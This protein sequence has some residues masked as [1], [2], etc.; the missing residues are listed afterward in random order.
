MKRFVL[1]LFV[2]VSCPLVS[3]GQSNAIDTLFSINGIPYSSQEFVEIYQENSLNSKKQIS[4]T[5]ALDL[6]ILFQLKINEAK[7]I[8]IDTL[9]E[10]KH[11]IQIG[12]DIAFNAFLYPRTIS[13][14]QIQEAHERLQYF[15]RAQQ[16]LVKVSKRANAKDTLVA[17]YKAQEIYKNLLK[18]KSFAKIARKYSHDPLVKKND[19]QLGYFTAFD[20]DYDFETAAYT[21]SVGAF[22]KPVH[23]TF[24]YHIIQILEK[25]ANPGKIKFRHILLDYPKNQEQKTKVKIDSLYSILM[26]GADFAE[27]AKKYST[28]DQTL[29]TKEE[30]PWFGLYETNPKIEEIAFKLKEIGEISKPIKTK[31]AYLI[32]QLVDRKDYSSLD[33]C[34][35]EIIELIAKDDR[36]KQSPSELITQIKKDYQ[37]TENRELLSNFYSIL[38]YAYADLWAPLFSLGGKDYSQE[39]FADY[40]SQQASKDIYENFI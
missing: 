28:D 36:S 22:S 26:R 12:R 4:L 31:D 6:Y 25:T 21:L 11:D 13:E 20:M 39:D 32:L 14:K 16:I 19:G 10:V 24:G 17:Y 15:I 35:K 30:L 1:Y 40:L 18:G 2:L 7:Q 34:R 3:F 38:D 37:F 29:Q 5:K 33:K 27:L 9:P 23:T 8:R